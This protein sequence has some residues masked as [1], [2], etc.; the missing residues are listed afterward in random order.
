MANNTEIDTPNPTYS[1]INPPSHVATDDTATRS[2]TSSGNSGRLRKASLKFMESGPPLGV[3]HAAGEALGKAPTPNDIIKGSFSHDGW[4]G[5]IQRRNSLVSDDSVRRL[6]RTTSSQTATAPSG[7]PSGLHAHQEAEVENE[8][9]PDFHA[10]G[11]MTNQIFTRR[12]TQPH[13]D[14]DE[15]AP[16]E[17]E[18]PLPKI[19]KDPPI[20]EKPAEIPNPVTTELGSLSPTTSFNQGPD[21]N[22]V[23]PNGYKFPPKHTRAEA[24]KIGFKAFCRYAITI[25][26]F[27]VVIY[28]LNIVAWGGMLFL[29]LIGGGK[30]YMCYPARLHGIKDCDDLYSPRRIWIEI[31]SLILTGLFCVTGL[32][33]I[34]WRFRDLYYLLKWRLLRKQ[35]G[36]R[37]LGGIHNGWF[38]LPGS[39]K[40]PVTSSKIDELE[41]FD[42]PATPLP[43]SKTPP[44][45]LTGIRAPD[46]KPWKLDLVIWSMVWNTFLQIVLCYF[47]WH[48]SRFDR[49][50]W[51]TG[52][53][54]ALACIV[55]AVGGLV[56]FQEAKKVKAV[57]GIPI[58]EEATLRDIEQGER[59]KEERKVEKKENKLEK[60]N[61]KLAKEGKV[62]R[63]HDYRGR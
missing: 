18:R 7:K 19:L 59:N 8:A 38:R 47:M 53:F 4:D 41:Y 11:E 55:A 54:I 40:L 51:A 3:W 21:A 22:G 62:E 39:H 25:Q 30:Q 26:G 46:T 15:L 20:V 23:Y 10:R 43:V 45:P 60:K 34:P 50:T 29:L 9:F 6:A 35:S 31:D 1:P 36:L 28:C 14:D 56:T 58:E 42:N 17:D 16:D 12:A 13:D 63:K 32:G 61:A 2:R 24:T 27:L 57:E 52:T 5:K 44:E 49:P 48:Y 37:K 33:L